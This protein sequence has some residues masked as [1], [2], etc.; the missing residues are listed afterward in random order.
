[1]TRVTVPL[2]D[3]EGPIP[4]TPDSRIFASWRRTR[5]PIDLEAHGYLEEEYFLSGVAHSFAEPDGQLQAGEQRPYRTRV[6]VRRPAEGGSRTAWLSILNA[7]QGYDIEDD[8]RRA[9]DTVIRRR[10]V[11]V[12]LTAKPI[13]V[14]A[15]INY[16]ATRYGSLSFGGPTPGL[17]AQ[18]GWNPF[19]VLPEADESLAWEIIAQTARWIRSGTAFPRPEM[20]A[21]TGQSQ[22]GIYTNTY[23]TSFHDVL[24]DEQDRPVIDGYLPGAA[25]VLVR[26]AAQADPGPEGQLIAERPATLDVGA[27][28]ISISTDGD[29]ALFGGLL[30]GGSGMFRTGDGPMRRHWHVAGTPHSDARSRVIPTND[31]IE[32]AGR[33]GRDLSTAVLDAL[34]VVPV[35]PVIAAAMEALAAWVLDGTPAPASRWFDADAADP[36]RIAQG[37]DGMSR[38]GIRCGLIEHPLA[39]FLP[40]VPDNP[41]MG[42]MQMRPREEI[43]A[44]YSDLTAYMRQCDAVDLPLRD[45]G[46]LDDAGITLLHEIEAELWAR[47]VDGAH[48]AAVTPQRV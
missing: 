27:P 42:R 11:Y 20:V 19:Q 47:A 36:E 40:A 31:E 34:D 41:V 12:A 6:I 1:M 26:D 21:L 5:D 9:W 23:L 16:D 13:N 32:R 22:S 46:Y 45:S 37:D 4:E 14:D 7:S 15:L 48:A 44:E 10:D 8:W 29:V 35:E 33:L 38:G 28:V 2:P 30:D 18:E 17:Q 24:V 3:V 43:L 39:G 25:S